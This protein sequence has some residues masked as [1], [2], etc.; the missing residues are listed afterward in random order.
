MSSV[1]AACLG[2]GAGGWDPAIEPPAAAPA[3]TRRAGPG[4]RPPPSAQL[5]PSALAWLAV[6]LRFRDRHRQRGDPRPRYLHRRARPGPDHPSH[7][8][9]H[10]RGGVSLGSVESEDHRS[11]SP[12][13]LSE[14]RDMASGPVGERSGRSAEDLF[15]VEADALLGGSW[16]PEGVERGVGH[17]FRHE[18]K[19]PLAGLL[20]AEFDE[21]NGLIERLAD[22]RGLLA[23]GTRVGPVSEY[24]SPAR[25]SWLRAAAA[26]AAISAGSMTG[27]PMSAKGR[28]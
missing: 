28:R 27:R 18:P 21:L 9:P 11:S 20:P 10:H 14:G 5:S 6:W 26:T 17:G 15:D 25:P 4:G 8:R 16:L 23:G 19:H 3:Q 12:G 2:A 7:P 1:C 24:A 13:A 22:R